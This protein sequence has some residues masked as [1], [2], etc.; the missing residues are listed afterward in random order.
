MRALAPALGI[1]LSAAF[2]GAVWAEGRV[3]G[4]QAARATLSG[5]AP[6]QRAVTVTWQGAATPATLL[7]PVRLN[8][9]VVRPAAVN[10]LAAWTSTGVS[11]PG[12]CRARGCPMLIDGAGVRTGETL[13][14]PGI[15]LEVGGHTSL[16]SAAPLGFMPGQ[17][18]GA[19]VLLGSD[20]AGLDRLPGLSSFYRTESWL[21]L[22]P[23]SRLHSWELPALGRRLQRDQATLLSQS[24]DFSL[25]A[26]FP[27][28]SA[29]AA[30]ATDAPRRLLLVAGGGIAALALFLALVVGG[31]R[32][33]AQ[34]ELDRLRTAGARSHQLAAFVCAECGLIGGVALLAG[35]AGAVAAAA[36]LAGVAHEPI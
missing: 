24:A 15:R 28:L 5:L 6:A 33:E 12:P 8:G 31:M 34:S 22:L 25:T 14:A 16:R 29:A 4:E 7:N 11:A 1:A 13:A 9:H 35:A 27:G 30:Q 26:P 2:L 3:A 20:P 23:V 19:P 32:H 10:P 21:A 18:P 36:L 17:S